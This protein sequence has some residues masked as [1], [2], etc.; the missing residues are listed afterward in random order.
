MIIENSSIDEIRNYAVSKGMKTLR[1]DGLE[2]VKNGVT[3]MEE[4]LRV[5]AE[6]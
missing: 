5:T 4:V 1:D 2:K 6:E 3:S